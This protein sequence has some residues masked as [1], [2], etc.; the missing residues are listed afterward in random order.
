MRQIVDH[1]TIRCDLTAMKQK[2]RGF[3]VRNGEPGKFFVENGVHCCFDTFFR[4]YPDE[5]AGLTARQSGAN[6][7][8]SETPRLRL[9]ENSGLRMVAWQPKGLNRCSGGVLVGNRIEKGERP[10][11]DSWGRMLRCCAL[12]EMLNSSNIDP[13]PERSMSWRTPHPS[14]HPP[15]SAN[16]F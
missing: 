16:P 4:W 3:V 6:I 9:F 7:D 15:F 14:T 1:R 5:I 12:R 11:R 8:A 2:D 13:R 10:P